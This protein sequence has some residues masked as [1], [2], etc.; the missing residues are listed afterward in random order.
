MKKFSLRI[1]GTRVGEVTRPVDDTVQRLPVRRAI[2]PRINPTLVIRDYR[3]D[4]PNG[5][6]G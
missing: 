2:V 3:D 4:E 6:V 5:D 1:N